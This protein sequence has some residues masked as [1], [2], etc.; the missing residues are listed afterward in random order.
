MI[1]TC[2][3]CNELLREGEWVRCE[4]EA[5]YK[6]LKSSVAYALYPNSMEIM[7]QLRHVNCYEG[8]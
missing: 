6:V 7:T 2:S 8:D 4:I 5:Q 1:K 3:K